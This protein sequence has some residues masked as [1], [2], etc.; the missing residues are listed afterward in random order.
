MVVS[1]ESKGT[2][3]LVGTSS[4]DVGFISFNEKGQYSKLR[5]SG[6]CPRI[7]TMYMDYGAIAYCNIVTLHQVTHINNFNQRVVVMFYFQFLQ[8]LTLIVSTIYTPLG[9]IME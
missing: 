6:I 1:H 2:G 3:Y 9:A 8:H 7:F 5:D 4:C